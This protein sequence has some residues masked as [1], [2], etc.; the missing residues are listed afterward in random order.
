LLQAVDK[1]ANRIAELMGEGKS[2]DVVE[3]QLVPG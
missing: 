3:L 2:G 1:V